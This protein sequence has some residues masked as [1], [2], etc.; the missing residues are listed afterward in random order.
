[1]T[2]LR[3]TNER[4]NGPFDRAIY[5]TRSNRLE[6]LIDG[7]KRLRRAATR[8]EKCAENYLAMLTIAANMLWLRSCCG[9]CCGYSLQTRP[10]TLVV[11]RSST[12]LYLALLKVCSAPYAFHMSFRSASQLGIYC[13]L[14]L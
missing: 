8:H 13:K 5:R 14:V 3:E 1:M 7:L 10:S 9:Y 12:T 2:I 4:R 6:R 11:L